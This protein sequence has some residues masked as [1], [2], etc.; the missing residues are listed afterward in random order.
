MIHPRFIPPAEEK[1]HVLKEGEGLGPAKKVLVVE[2]D[3]VFSEILKVF[4]YQSGYSVETV[5]DGVQGIKRIM[6]GDYDFI[7]CDMVMSTLAGDMFYLAVERVRPHLCKRFI[8][9]KGSSI[10]WL[11]RIS[12]M[13]ATILFTTP[14]MSKPPRFA[15]TSKLLSAERAG[16]PLISITQGFPRR[17]VLK[18]I[19][20]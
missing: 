3:E 14:A 6:A 20:A 18:S 5:S 9:I 17:S 15:A 13:S 4:L 19:R 11:I 7:L 8:F 1:T 2:D 12:G 10:H 16:L